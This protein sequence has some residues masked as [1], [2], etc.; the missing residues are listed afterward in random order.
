[1]DVKCVFRLHSGGMLSRPP[2]QVSAVLSRGALT[3]DSRVPCSTLAQLC[4]AHLNDNNRLKEGNIQFAEVN[5]SGWQRRDEA[6]V[7]VPTEQQELVLNVM[8]V[9]TAVE[10]GEL[11]RVTLVICIVLTR[12]CAWHMRCHTALLLMLAFVLK[13][14]LMC[15]GFQ[16]QLMSEGAPGQM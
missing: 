4:C 13:V 5:A 1:M 10:P 9:P 3:A 14:P 12:L 6:E 7:E 8:V 15:A 11:P 2:Y 16:P